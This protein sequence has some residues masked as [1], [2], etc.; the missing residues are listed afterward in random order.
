MLV[1]AAYFLVLI[2]SKSFAAVCVVLAGSEAMVHSP[3]IQRK[4]CHN[5]ER[6]AEIVIGVHGSRE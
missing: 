6:D 1:Q 4:E 3:V 5:N 2:P